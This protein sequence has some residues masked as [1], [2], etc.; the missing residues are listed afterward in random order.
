[1][2]LG[3]VFSQKA[4]QS[5][6][7]GLEPMSCNATLLERGGWMHAKLH[8]GR[9]L[10]AVTSTAEESSLA[11]TKIVIFGCVAFLL[12][13]VLNASERIFFLP[14]GRIGSSLV[15]GFLMVL[16]GVVPTDDV[17]TLLSSNLALLALVWGAMV[18]SHYLKEHGRL[19]EAVDAF[20]RWRSQG[21]WDSCARLSIASSVIAALLG[22]DVAALLLAP[23]AMKISTQFP[24]ATAKP[25]LSAIATGANAGSILTPAS[26]P[27]NVIV[28]LASGMAFSV[29]SKIM[30]LPCLLAIVVNALVVVGSYA[31]LLFKSNAVE[32]CE[33][34]T[35]PSLQ[36]DSVEEVETP[37]L[38]PEMVE[39]DLA[40][41]QSREVGETSSEAPEEENATAMAKVRQFVT[42]HWRGI[43]AYLTWATVLIVWFTGA[44]LGA[45]A[46]AGATALILAEWKDAGEPMTVS[47]EWPV[48]AYIAGILITIPGFNLTG[49]PSAFWDLVDDGMVSVVDPWGLLGLIA[50]TMLFTNI[51]TNVPAVLLLGQRVA[52]LAVSELDSSNPSKLDS[53]AAMRGWLLVA[54]IAAMSGSLTVQ[55]SITQVIAYEVG[56]NADGGSVSFMEHLRVGV[57]VTVLTLA[58][59]LPLLLFL[60]EEML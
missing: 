5:E 50:V 31:N 23:L 56:K 30:A 22:W 41:P 4:W 52:E 37:P 54:F 53:P 35:V 18:I 36:D 15:S 32:N 59:G 47:A 49:L 14:V 1:M 13:V 12:F 3:S 42:Q 39:I 19:V 28:T 58:L 44:E 34:P 11:D 38:S 45:V 26:N 6:L 24:H 46:A 17:L 10:A 21:A 55:G 48:I 51:V 60:M 20:C 2:A 29:F 40:T 25:F 43:F 33:N 7:E 16:L 57:P 9:A 27:G 8:V